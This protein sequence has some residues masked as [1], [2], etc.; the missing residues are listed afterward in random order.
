MHGIGGRT[1]EELANNM[2]VDEFLNWFL[3]Y[4][5][6]PFGWDMIG[7]HVARIMHQFAAAN[8]KHPTQFKEFILDFMPKDPQ[9]E[10]EMQAAFAAWVALAESRQEI[11]PD[12]NPAD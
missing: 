10:D 7:L 12:E 8:S 5:V 6:Q 1:I 3:Y 2:S 11:T 4:E 9:D